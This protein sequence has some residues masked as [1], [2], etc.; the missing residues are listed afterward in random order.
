MW[1]ED[2]SPLRFVD[3]PERT[4]VDAIL[5]VYGLNRVDLLRDR[6]AWA[7]QRSCQQSP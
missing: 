3:V 6:F 5:G 2:L 7:Y 4:C 1:R